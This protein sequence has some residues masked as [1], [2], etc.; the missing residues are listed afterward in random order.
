M[1]SCVLPVGGGEELWLATEKV[2]KGKELLSTVYVALFYIII[3]W[4]DGGW[5][6][7]VSV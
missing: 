3:F 6:A 4:G 2:Y 7:G 5:G 1:S